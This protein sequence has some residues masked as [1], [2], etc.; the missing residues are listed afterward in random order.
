MPELLSSAV[1]FFGAAIITMMASNQ[2]V[3][4]AVRLQR[5][6]LKRGV[7]AQGRILR[8]W[9]P[10]PFGAFTRIYFE[11]ELP[12]RARAVRACHVDRRFGEPTAS[13]PAVGTTVSVRYLPEN[14]T[15]AVIARLVSGF[16]P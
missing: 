11:F 2:A 10:L 1:A 5:E 8:I 7:A 6:I 13:L 12:E 15:K 3:S 4:K 16:G 9:R 14:P